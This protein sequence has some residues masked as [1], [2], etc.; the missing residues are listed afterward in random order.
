MC[1]CLC[2]ADDLHFDTFNTTATFAD[3]VL[4]QEFIEALTSVNEIATRIEAT[5]H[6]GRSVNA[7]REGERSR[8][9]LIWMADWEPVFI[10]ENDV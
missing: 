6:N 1:S 9:A 3:V 10:M 8:L 4:G 5:T 2:P 7:R